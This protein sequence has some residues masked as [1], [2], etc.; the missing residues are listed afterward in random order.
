LAPHAIPTLDIPTERYFP[1]STDVYSNP[2]HPDHAVSVVHDLTTGILLRSIQNGYALEL[3]NLDLLIAKNTPKPNGPETLRISFPEPLRPLAKG[4]ILTSPHDGKVHILLLTTT[5]VLYRLTFPAASEGRFGFATKN[6]DDWSE[7]WVVPEDVIEA[8]GGVGAWEVMDD[9]TV[10]LGGGDGGIVRLKRD[11]Q[12]KGVNWTATHHRS[13]SK[14]RL[15]SLFSKSS[16]SDEQIV[17]LAEYRRQ[18]HTAIVYSLSRD[19]KLRTWNADTGSWLKAVDVRVSS[20]TSQ[21]LVVRGSPITSTSA[22]AALLPPTFSVPLIHVVPHPSRASRY[23]H[24]VVVFLATP[25]STSAGTFVVYRASISGHHVNDLVYAG[26]R[27]CSSSSAG[28]ELRGFE[29][30]SPIKEEGIDSG[31]RL[32]ATWDKDG[33]VVCETLTMDDIFQFTTYVEPQD[34]SPLLHDWLTASTPESEQYDAAY[35]DNLLGLEC[36][37]PADPHDNTDISST[38]IQ[39]LFHPGRFSVL[40]LATAL[41]EYSLQ[42]PKRGQF[43]QLSVAYASLSKKY[44]GIVGCA[45]SMGVSAST[46][47]PEVENY[48][49]AL[50]LE[51]LGIWARVR[52]LDKQARWPVSTSLAS[53]GIMLVLSR[54][55]F[56][57]PVPQDT[58]GLITHI[59]DNE[60]FQALPEGALRKMYPSLAPPQ[61]RRSAAAISAAGSYMATILADQ[62][63]PDVGEDCLSAL[64]DMLVDTLAESAAQPVEDLCGALWD[65]MVDPYLTKEERTQLSCFLSDCAHVRRGLLEILDVLS[66]FSAFLGGME[67]SET[68]LSGAGNALLVST[69][70]Q[71]VSSRSTLARNVI[72]VC[73][74]HL[75]E[76]PAATSEDDESEELV[77]VLSR[78]LV[79]YH[80]YRILR[81]LCDQTGEEARERV[82][83]KRHLKRKGEDGLAEGFGSLKVREGED[84]GLDTDGYDP[85]Y[86]LVHSLIA[87]RLPQV[88]GYDQSSTALAFLSELGVVQK[89]AI[90]TEPLEADVKLA[91]AIYADGHPSLAREWTVLYPLTA[92]MAYIRGRAGLDAGDVD[93]AVSCFEKASSGCR[94]GSLA[95]ILPFCTGPSALS[96]YYR[97][98][99]RLF[100]G[101]AL[102]APTVYFGRLAVEKTAP[103]E[104]DSQTIKD[105]WGRMFLAH[106][107]LKE[108][109][110][111]YSI[112]TDASTTDLKK[113]LLGQLI[114]LMCEN[115]QVGLLNTLGFVGFQNEVE[116]LLK[117]KARNSD[118][119]RTPNYYKVLY[120]RHISRGDYRSA[121]EIMYLQGRRLAEGHSSKLP[122]F[123]TS[124]MQARSYLAAINALALVDKRNAWVSVP[125]TAHRTNMRVKRRKVST[126]IPET[127]FTQDKRAVDIVSLADIEMEYTLVLSQLRLSA[128]IQDLQQYGITVSPEEVVGLFTQRGM[129]DL[130]QSAAASLQVD[131][132]DLFQSL[133]SRCVVLARSPDTTMTSFLQT[134]PLTSRLRGPP[135][136]IALRYLEMSLSRH[137]SKKTNFKYRQAV[138]DTMFEMNGNKNAGYQIPVWLADWEMKRDP[139]GWIARALR[140]GWVEEALDWTLEL[141]RHATPPEL[142]PK[143]K[144][145]VQSLPYNL[146]DRVVAACGEGDEKEDKGIQSKVGMLR[147]QLDKR[148]QGLAKV[149]ST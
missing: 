136:A 102:H 8:C 68:A 12:W 14:F 5:N 34:S 73:I 83:S 108:Y 11:G 84:E 132:T 119:L 111:A 138:A 77:L 133:A 90:D 82:G 33:S 147:N 30:L 41:D 107:Q 45:L 2:L 66:D 120:S 97:S 32:W 88:A 118:P 80:R 43:L 76:S 13:S 103:G 22:T 27:H 64:T 95:V 1:S 39:H 56:A 62:T 99:S 121:G 20:S 98:V 123:E 74:Y 78:A 21:D 137:D 86:S 53:D 145:F 36:P 125:P 55:G 23:S 104:E 149:D 25:Y 130:A 71:I 46:G 35:F 18:D 105:L 48:R 81:W 37:N 139:E 42:L 142:L 117:Y 141:L 67:Q 57:L 135:S 148:V 63:N 29:V 91:H 65:E 50:K 89:G 70:A 69:L 93:L 28:A 79:V 47:A 17:S 101:L 51:W 87:H 44:N 38:F 109:E 143:G 122:V 144:T 127:E 113:D 52:N 60:A 16:T 131:M 94:D 72:L 134:S 3:R 54:E 59:Q 7:E 110:Q 9:S 4:C 96:E 115:E 31:W 126:Y 61:A 128:Q 40:T 106:V 15:P 26:E 49:K 58:V 114:S 140:W 124:A 19:R 116:K 129:F 112:L 10:I 6:H 92:G 24:L 100:D 146:I 85:A 75:S